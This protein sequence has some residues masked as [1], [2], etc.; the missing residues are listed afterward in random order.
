MSFGDRVARG[1]KA[2]FLARVVHIVSNAALLVALT[3]YLLT[4]A[5][6]G[7]LGT[8]LA[9]LGVAMLFGTLGVPKATA[10]YLTEYV[11]TD[12]RQIPHLI[13]RTTLVVLALAV[14][15]GGLVAATNGVIANLLGDATLAPFFVLG[16][17]YVVGKGITDHL[18]I[19]F[20]GFNRVTW[21]AVV[22]AINGLARVAFAVGFVLLGFGALGALA[23][24]VV[25]FLLSGAV[26]L[27]ILYWKFYRRY[28]PAT[29]REE[30]LVRR[31]LEY[32]V[33]TTAT[34]ASVVVD[35]KV[36]TLLLAALAGPTAVAFYTLARQISNV[37]IVP[38]QSLGFTITPTFGEQKAA[39]SIS[40]AARLYER[41]LENVLLLYVPAG[42]G[43]ALVAEPAVRYIF[44]AEYLGAVPIVQLFAAFILV[45]A[46]HKITGS[47]LDYLGLARVRAVARGAS[48]LGNVGLNLL[49]IPRYGAV[50]AGA[51]T[52]VTYTLYTLVNVYYVHREFS[53]RL[54]YLG[55]RFVRIVAV[56]AVMGG[57]V[58]LVLPYVDGLV[59]L[60]AAIALGGAVWAALS[61]LGGLVDLAEVRAFLG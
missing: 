39:D 22:G 36:D 9:A 44:T 59:T 54:G 15:V 42:V 38:A 24:Y 11:E 47:G 18:K 17:L 31:V 37:C 45:R 33:P 14:V 1:I 50:G 57:G 13:R 41:A 53:L 7:R 2:S 51:A 6:Y 4:P 60:V 35:S 46:V 49:L 56:A 48:A 27:A 23:G 25:A 55:R 16:A 10:R 61:V 43:L 19:L 29:E 20:Q 26:G 5:E 12:D 3:R 30:G 34:R 28:E 32:S 40:R 52:V 58:V 21:S 8:A